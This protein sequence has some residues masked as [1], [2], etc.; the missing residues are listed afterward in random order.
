M[1]KKV[2]IIIAV[3]LF[4]IGIILYFVFRETKQEVVKSDINYLVIGN[5]S[6][7]ENKN[8][9]WKKVTYDD[10]NNKKLS[11]YIDN[12]YSGKY[13]LK[14]GKVWNLYDNSGLVMYEDSFV[15]MSDVNWDIVNINIDSISKEDLI[16]INSVLNSKYSLED[17]TLNE[18][19]NVDF[20]NNGIIDT[21]INVGNLNRDGLDKYFSFVYVIIDGKKEILINEDIDVKDNLNYPIYRINSLL[22]KNGLINIIL[23]KGY[24]SEAGTNGNKMYEIID[25]KYE[26]AIED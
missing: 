22:R 8:N 2:P 16:Y 26:L 5:E 25:G 21:I 11:V 17:I 7:W 6:I 3:I 15:A 23:H 20:N 10:V 18:K 14:Y 9:S 13:T 1:N 12:M 19:V 4:V 24:F